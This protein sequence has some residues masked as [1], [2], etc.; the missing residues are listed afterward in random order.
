MKRTEAISSIRIRT[1][2]QRRR[3]GILMA[4]TIWIMLAACLIAGG[5]FNVMYTSGM[6][7]Q[8]HHSASSAAIAAGYG[9]LSDDML[10][11]R[12]EPFEIEGRMTRC[13]Q[14]ALSIA[15]EYRRGTSLPSLTEDDIRLTLPETSMPS[16]DASAH[17]PSEIAVCFDG[18]NHR[19]TLPQ[20]FSGLTGYDRANLGVMACVKLEHSPIGFRPGNKLSVPMLP[21]A[22]CDK[23]I[24]TNTDDQDGADDPEASS[25]SLAGGYWTSNIESG[26]GRDAFSWNEESRQFENGPDGLPEITVTI[27][28]TSSV[29][30]EDAF[31]PMPFGPTGVVATTNYSRWIHQGLTAEDLSSSG[32][33]EVQFPGT[34]NVGMLTPAD[35]PSCKMALETKIGEPSIICLCS[36]A[37]ASE[38]VTSMTLERPVSARIVQVTNAASGSLRVV[39]QPCVMTTS[40]AVTSNVPSA[41]LNRYI[42]SVRLCQ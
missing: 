35:L 10:R 22:I 8:A 24:S 39:L 12:Q 40:T 36:L 15:E 19:N 21:F 20:F 3:A 16:N 17:V 28:S 30:H 7:T 5:V 41:T 32:Q 33:A 11:F 6:R 18:P 26:E 1:R 38:G 34:M 29:G 27:Y 23:V 4:W 31:I 13:R 2:P 25:N 14:K 42:Y 37:S 9:Y